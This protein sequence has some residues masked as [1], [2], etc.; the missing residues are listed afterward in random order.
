LAACNF[1]NDNTG[2]KDPGRTR[3][4]NKNQEVAS[5]LLPCGSGNLTQAGENKAG[6]S[7]EELK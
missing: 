7:H 6:E 2:D 3:K 5:G 1:L 4:A